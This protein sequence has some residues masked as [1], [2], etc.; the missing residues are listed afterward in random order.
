VPAILRL[1]GVD[2]GAMTLI[3]GALGLASSGVIPSLRDTP[4]VRG[5]AGRHVSSA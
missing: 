5:L 2:D 3:A 4:R 1:M